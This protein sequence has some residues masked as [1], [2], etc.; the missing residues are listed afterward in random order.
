DAVVISLVGFVDGLESGD[1]FNAYADTDASPWDQTPFISASTAVNFSGSYVLDICRSSSNCSVGFELN[2]DGSGGSYG[3]SIF[4]GP[5]FSMKT[6]DRHVTDR[7]DLS[8]GTSMAAPH[9]AGLAAL[10][11]SYSPAYTY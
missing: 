4:G 11:L 3:L 6:L 8:N 10:I 5:A 7:Y 2:E 9:V 1:S